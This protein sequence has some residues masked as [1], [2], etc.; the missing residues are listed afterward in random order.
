MF[1]LY[2]EPVCPLFWWLNAPK[3]GR[4][5]NQNKGHVG[6]RYLFLFC[7]VEILHLIFS[8][9]GETLTFLGIEMFKKRK[10]AMGLPPNHPF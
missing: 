2:L 6:S 1:F 7:F 10:I 8:R 9:Q 4:T 3:Q 5:S